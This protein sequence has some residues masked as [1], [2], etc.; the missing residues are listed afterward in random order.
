MSEETI[1]SAAP[2]ETPAPATEVNAWEVPLA[3]LKQAAGID[4]PAVYQAQPA[5]EPTAVPQPFTLEEAADGFHL[6]LSP[7][8][9]GEVFKGKDLNEVV[10]K[11]AKSKAD[12]NAYI[13]QLKQWADEA[14]IN[15][16]TTGAMPQD[17][18]AEAEQVGAL[19]DFFKNEILTPEMKASIVA[20]V[21]GVPAEQLPDF[22]Q[23][24]ETQSRNAALNNTMTE[25]RVANPT[26]ADSPEHVEG[27]MKALGHL[28]P[29]YMPT[30]QDLQAAWARALY[31][32]WATPY[33]P[34]QVTAP[35][36]PPIM[37]NASAPAL[38]GND[39]PYAMPLDQLKK[40]AGL[41]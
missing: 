7:E 37:P 13:K 24:I 38:Q 39:N 31:E 27:I 28:P 6:K 14:H 3:D 32:G 34:K 15:P 12:G 16:G 35:P 18:A 36:R 4:Q 11:L 19:R 41:T 10:S 1:T 17:Q 29:T 8:Y 26:F 5:A 9:G 40:A 30:P 25:F 2:I 20:D 22:L 21:V 33:I 23:T